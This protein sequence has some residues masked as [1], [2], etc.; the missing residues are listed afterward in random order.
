[1]VLEVGRARAE[2]F[3]DD[4]RAQPIISR[5]YLRRVCCFLVPGPTRTPHRTPL[6]LSNR[7]KLRSRGGQ[8]R[9][10]LHLQIPN[11]SALSPLSHYSSATRHT[12]AALEGHSRGSNFQHRSHFEH[13]QRR[14]SLGPQQRRLCRRYRRRRRLPWFRKRRGEPGLDLAAAARP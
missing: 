8:N 12:R 1:M 11:P 4:L 9:S 7:A 6:G 5:P 3:L 2:T 10:R 13:T 14:A